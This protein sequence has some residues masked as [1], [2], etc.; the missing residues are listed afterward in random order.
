MP[1]TEVA[2]IAALKRALNKYDTEL[3]KAMNKEIRVALK[4]VQKS[5]RDLVPA[6]LGSGL[7]N[8]QGDSTT[9]KSRTSRKRAFPKFDAR[10]VKRGIVITT[11]ASKQSKN[12]WRGYYSLINRSAAGAIIETSGRLYPNGDPASQSNNPRAGAHFINVLNHNVGSL[13]KYGKGR[14]SSGRIIYRAA[15]EDQGKTRDAI[16]KALAKAREVLVLGYGKAA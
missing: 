13:G 11:G 5:A 16:I 10:E 14:K 3:Y 2:D 1:A 12:G 8:F 6:Y 9:A 15:E 7:R 4:V